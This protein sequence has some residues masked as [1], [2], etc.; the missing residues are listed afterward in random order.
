M[1][2]FPPSGSKGEKPKTPKGKS[3]P[4]NNVKPNRPNPPRKK[5]EPM[6]IRKKLKNASSR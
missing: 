1:S 6:H 4:P 2:E 3:N 5:H